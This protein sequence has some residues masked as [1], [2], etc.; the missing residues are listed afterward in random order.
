MKTVRDSIY[1]AVAAFILYSA[2]I[3]IANSNMLI[4]WGF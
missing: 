3:L 4:E 2:L 1:L